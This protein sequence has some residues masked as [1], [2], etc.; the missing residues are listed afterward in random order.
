MTHLA[1]DY[2]ECE[3]IDP[4]A[5]V[6]NFARTQYPGLKFHVGSSRVL[7]GASGFQP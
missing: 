2:G 4:V 1:S 7:M 3:S 5:P 6:I